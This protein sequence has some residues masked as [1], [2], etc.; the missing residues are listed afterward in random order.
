MSDVASRLFLAGVFA[1]AKRTD[2]KVIAIN[3]DDPEANDL[4]DI[5]DVRRLKPGYLEATVDWFRRYK[6]PDGKPENQFAFNGEFKDKDFAIKV[7]KSTH[8]FWKALIS[9]Q[10]NAGELNCKNTRVSKG[11]SS[12][13]CSPEDAKAIVDGTCPCGAADSIPT[14]V[15]KW[16]YYEKSLYII[17]ECFLLIDKQGSGSEKCIQS[18]RC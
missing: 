10:T 14:S 16:N 18:N 1:G 4:N 7:I 2:W 8:D 6:V 12:F 5:S 13:C 15:D 17:F 11:G 3:V 9:E